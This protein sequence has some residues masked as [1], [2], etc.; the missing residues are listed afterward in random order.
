MLSCVYVPCEGINIGA[1]SCKYC[2]RVKD[3]EAV[4]GRI[5]NRVV[6]TV[7]ETIPDRDPGRCRRVASVWL[8]ARMACS[9]RMAMH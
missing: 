9:D 8:V 6:F 3:P 2:G 1:M 4:P 7:R 5:F